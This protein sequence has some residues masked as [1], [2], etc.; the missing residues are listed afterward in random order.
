MKAPSQMESIII[1]ILISSDFPV[2]SWQDEGAGKKCE[3]QTRL[4]EVL[5]FLSYRRKESRVGRKI[6]KTVHY[7]QITSSPKGKYYPYLLSIKEW[8]SQALKLVHAKIIFFSGV[9]PAKLFTIS[10]FQNNL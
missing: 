5:L 9:G 7:G 10:I 3:L 1:S 4:V 6:R 2:V 8:E